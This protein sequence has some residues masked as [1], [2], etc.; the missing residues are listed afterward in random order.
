VPADGVRRAYRNVGKGL[1]ETEAAATRARRPL[2][3]PRARREAG[4][5]WIAPPRPGVVLALVVGALAVGG[6]P[7][8]SAEPPA[9]VYLY[10][11]ARNPMIPVTVRVNGEPMGRL[12]SQSVFRWELAP[13]TYGLFARSQ[14][15]AASLRITVAPGQ[16]R[17]IELAV[18][19]GF[20]IRVVT[21]REQ[22]AARGVEAV[23]GMTPLGGPAPSAPVPP[24]G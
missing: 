2:A 11:E 18:V 19:L 15:N 10:R 4:G 21:L 1:V 6:T 9:V 7:R 13:G 23:R 16:T 24:S 14:T 17:W 22:P 8:A 12:W 5:M 20:Q 3:E